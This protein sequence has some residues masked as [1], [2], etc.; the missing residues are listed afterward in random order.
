LEQQVIVL[1]ASEQTRRL[2]AFLQ[3]TEAI[4]MLRDMGYREPGNGEPVEP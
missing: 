4:Q 3:S 2:L 1:R